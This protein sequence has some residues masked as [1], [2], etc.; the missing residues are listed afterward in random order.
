MWPFSNN[1]SA[2]SRV[3]TDKIVPLHLFDDIGIFRANVRQLLRYD[4]VL[5]VDKLRSALLELFERPDWHRLGARVRI[6]VG[7]YSILKDQ[8]VDVCSPRENWSST[9]LPLST[10]S[11]HRLFSPTHR[12][13]NVWKSI[14]LLRNCHDRVL[15]Q[16]SQKTFAS[17]ATC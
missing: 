11:D 15:S 8:S 16:S 7:V 10:R 12:T 2:P 1:A 17:S 6:N 14:R 5:D 13:T 3:T 9:Y 4:E